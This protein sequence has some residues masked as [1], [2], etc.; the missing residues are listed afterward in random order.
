VLQYAD[1]KGN[2]EVRRI[3]AAE[4]PGLKAGDVILA[5]GAVAA[6]FLLHSSLLGAGDRLRTP[7]LSSPSPLAER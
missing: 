4:A 6:L 3:I 2:P 1:H 7:S 5:P